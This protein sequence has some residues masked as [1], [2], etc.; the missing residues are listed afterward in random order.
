MCNLVAIF[1]VSASHRH[2][3]SGCT[4]LERTR[5]D[6]G[7]APVQQTLC[8]ET[9]HMLTDIKRLTLQYGETDSGIRKSAD[10][11][12]VPLFSR[13]AESGSATQES[14]FRVLGKTV[15]RRRK[16]SAAMRKSPFGNAEKPLSQTGHGSGPTRKR[17]NT[18]IINT[19]PQDSKNSRK[20]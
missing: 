2:R 16:A 12:S 4:A 13:L 10:K 18:L 7:N 15:S 3:S 8:Q 9:I 19:L 17:L 14:L 5:H 11:R 6:G 20:S 1:T